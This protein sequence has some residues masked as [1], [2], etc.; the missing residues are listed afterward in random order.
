MLCSP[1]A[2]T[3]RWTNAEIESFKR[4][5]PEGCVLA[6]VVGGEPFASDIAGRE[7][8]ECFPPA[9]RYKYDRR[10]HQT[11]KRAEPLAAD[12]RQSGEGRR[13]AFLKLVAGMLGVGLD[14][15]VQ[16]ETTRRHR[17]L[18][19]VAAGSLVGMAVTST[20]AV[21]AFQ[22]RNEAREQ[23]REAEGLVAFM[24]GDL[25][26]KLEPIGK[27]DALDGV[28]SRVLAYYSKQD[29]SQLSDAALSQRAQALSLMAQV[30]NS[31]GDGPTALK[32]YRQALAGTAE[33]MRRDPTNAQAVFDHA[34]NVFY[35]G[36]IAQLAD[37]Y[38]TAEGSMREYQR[39]ARRM[40][41]L[42]PDNMKFRMEEQYADADLGIVLFDQRRFQEATA[43]FAAA[44]N[45]MHAI[46][47]ADPKNKAYRQSVAES[48]AWLA[49]SERAQGHYDRAIDLRK[50][51][52]SLY[53]QLYARY[54]DMKFRERVVPAHRALGYLYLERGQSAL[55][56]SEFRSAI[57]ISDNLRVVEPNNTQWL[58]SGVRAR[59]YLAKMA[60]QSGQRADAAPLIEAACQISRALLQRPSPKTEWKNGMSVCFTMMAEAALADGRYD[61]ALTFARRS[62]DIADAT[63]SDNIENAFRMARSLRLIGDIQQRAG[64]AESAHAAW[65]NA[66]SLFPKNVAEQPDELEEHAA[67]LRRLNRQAEAQPLYSRL[68]AMGY[69]STI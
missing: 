32:L 62:K 26:D 38:R 55:A 6:A 27:L 43:Q 1:T 14:E 45:M 2:A 66:L 23:R 3:S 59:L 20:L 5:R 37:D 61:T 68:N 33:A 49:D 9:L 39:L 30:A 19:W 17:Q 4:T 31:R 18:A 42:Q 22:A 60:I 50:R 52:I 67:L 58:E 47:T 34:Q 35:V 57:A 44:L 7:A 36:E 13:L 40:N 41:A 56:A 10:G 25:K 24:L 46:A 16:R 51:C 64:N 69:R 28:G 15:L 8:E 29:T 12:F 48:L 11:A 65:S 63:K 54:N 21:T 53:D